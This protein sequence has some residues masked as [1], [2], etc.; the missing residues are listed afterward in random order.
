MGDDGGVVPVIQLR[1]FIQHAFPGGF[2]DARDIIQDFGDRVPGQVE[3]PGDHG[4][5]RLGSHAIIS[6]S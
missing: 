4:L 3:L 2:G 1:R 5:C 6:S